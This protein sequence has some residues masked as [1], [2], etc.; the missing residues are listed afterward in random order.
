MEQ[1]KMNMISTGAFLPEMD[2]SNQ[3]ETVAEKFARVW[4]KKNSK[5]A[6]AGGVSLMALSL[7]ACGSSSSDTDTSGS[8]GS[9]GASDSDGT[10]GGSSGST[11]TVQG[12]A[13]A[14]GNTADVI[15]PNSATAAT[16]S[17]DGNDTFRAASSGDLTSS[18]VINAGGGTAD[19][20]NATIEDAAGA[21][22]VAPMLSNLEIV[23]LT[24]TNGDVAN[25]AVTFNQ[26]DSTGINTISVTMED[27]VN[28]IVSNANLSQSIKFNDG[29][30]TAD[31]GVTYA[32]AAL[33]TATDGGSDSATVSMEDIDV[34]SYTSAGIENLTINV[35]GLAGD[36]DTLV[37]TSLE[38][39]TIT[40]G[41]DNPDATTE[42]FVL[43]TNAA[44]DNSAIDFDG[45]DT[46]EVAEIDA[47][48]STNSVTLVVD[49]SVDLT[50]TGGAG[51]LTIDNTSAGAGAAAATAA[52]TITAGSGGIDATIEGG[53]NTAGA[54]AMT[55]VSITGSAADDTVDITGVVDG[56]DITAT[57]GVDESATTNVT[58]ST[59]SG[60][61]AVT[62]DAGLVNVSTGAG[63]DTLTVTTWASVTADD[64]I[65]LGDGEDTVVTSEATLGSG[66]ATAMARYTGAEVVETTA[67]AEKTISMVAL[68]TVSSAVASGT[69]AATAQTDTAS[70]AGADALDFTS[71]DAT[72]TLTV[73]ALT[74]QV[75]G[76]NANATGGVGGIGLDA[77]ATLD[78]G[79]N[80][81][82][83]TLVDNADIAGGAGGAATGNNNNG[84]AGGA[85]ID[86]NEYETVNLVLSATD[87]TADVVAI[88]GGNGGA[89]DGTGQNG[90]AGA[91][92]IVG[93]NATISITETLA[94]T[95]GTTTLTVAD[96]ISSIDLG[97]I[98]GTNVTVSAGTLN[99]NV[100]IAAVSGNTNITTGAGDD[101]IGG[102]AGVDNISTG[103]GDDTIDAQGGADTLTGGAGNDAFA[104]NAG[105]S[106]AAA[107]DVISGFNLATA[108]WTGAASNDQVTEFQSTGV[109][110]TDADVI[111]IEGAF[112][113][114]GDE[115]S[116][117]SAAG[118]ANVTYAVSD[119]IITLGGTGAAAIDTIA[120][121][122]TEV[123]AIST[124]TGGVDEVSAFEF[125]G[126]TYVFVNDTTDLLVQLDG[127]TGVTGIEALA[128]TGTIGGDGYIIIA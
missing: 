20:L 111:D 121:W 99:G 105:D 114:S 9:S 84:G 108:S 13:F 34:A 86:A 22:T 12:I 23:N 94:A 16:K 30:A 33:S 14:L 15:D 8:S 76:T 89:L 79:T 103:A 95:S 5:V 6:R 77:N 36:V 122:I 59:G 42:A 124:Q 41:V 19:T 123:E 127:I 18:D 115:T 27:D 46:D 47:S 110:G 50:V 97:T 118:T 62:I 56:T 113:V 71:N 51:L 116:T 83:I 85:A 72:G 3:Q 73:G 44:A 96:H 126:S 60:D 67:T 109:G 107:T 1:K 2:A 24:I 106:T 93:A 112:V 81:I 43:G 82:T 61:D 68:G 91:D 90:A 75:G 11:T 66:Q 78:D 125:S 87:T 100:T 80:E 35:S 25:A 26:V 38:K 102:G 98:T 49:D 88:T 64:V 31:A 45:L 117:A 48:Q 120:E 70:A 54:T 17:T 65:N 10:S 53:A 74:G 92:I 55:L 101:S 7:A 21:V 52:V 128:N 58:V 4:E 37:M 104:L 57:T 39:L 69:H 28:A 29:G 40:G 119:G 63:N 32:T